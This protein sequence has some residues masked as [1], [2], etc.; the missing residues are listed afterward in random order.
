M[1]C[2]SLGLEPVTIDVM[3]RP[4]R[5]PKAPIITRALI[6]NVLTSAFL[7]V[8]GTLY[9]FWSESGDATSTRDT[10]MTFTTFVFFDMFNALSCRS[11][12][13]SVFELGLT[14]NVPFLY[15]V[16]G[17]LIGQMCVVFF[18]PLQSV[19]QTEA[20]S[21]SVRNSSQHILNF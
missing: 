3:Q 5:D 16:G 10:T 17:S 13:R 15:A 18:P 21:A 2:S 20:L 8:S 14:S 19:F 1:F 11:P 4:P 9:V 6:G 7:I 12:D